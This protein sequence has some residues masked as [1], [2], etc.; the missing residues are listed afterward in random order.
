MV[1]D[2]PVNSETSVMTAIILRYIGLF[3]GGAHKGRV[4][5][6]VFIEVR[7]L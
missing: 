6:Y 2:L 5:V 3:F 7:A 1:G 4:Y